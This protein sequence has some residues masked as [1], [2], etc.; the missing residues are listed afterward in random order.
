MAK[1][2]VKIQRTGP[3]RL[4]AEQT[5]ELPNRLMDAAF[6]LFAERG[7]ADATMD[8]I[9]KRA[10]A[11]TKTLYS[12]FANKTELLEAVVQRNIE[13]T[14]L[15]HLRTFA[16]TPEASTPHDYLFRFGMQIA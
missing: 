4:S 12:R 3:G 13:H 7:F 6:N 15:A 2:A 5:E 14:V 10:G 16:L 11:S 8:D 1:T 9:A